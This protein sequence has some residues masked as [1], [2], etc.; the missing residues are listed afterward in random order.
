MSSY[1]EDLIWMSY[2]YCIGRKTI[3]ASMHAGNIAQN[4]YHAIPDD[5]KEFMAHD[6]RRE[7]NDT[8][9]MENVLITDYRDHIPEDA[10]SSILWKISMNY[11]GT[12]PKNWNEKLWKYDVKDGVV[13]MTVNPDFDPDK[14][15]WSTISREYEDLIPWI[16]LA[17][18]FD[19]STHR[20]VIVEYDGKVEEKTCFHFPIM[21]YNFD[22]IEEAWV[23]L[24]D[25]L[26]NPFVCSFINPEY[27]KEIK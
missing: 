12:P 14:N 1:L 10:L 3:A 15:Y 18:A 26:S 4:S 8:L 21:H 5:R 23:E 25:Y 22:K 19:K 11:N 9:C 27:I 16:K 17:N 7:I 24:N 13:T 20:T 6:I 2:R